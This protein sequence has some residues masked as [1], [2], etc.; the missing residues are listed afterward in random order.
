MLCLCHIIFRNIASLLLNLIKKLNMSTRI[1]TYLT[2]NG[3]CRQAMSFYK[4]C[5]GGELQLQ[6][7]GDSPLAEKMPKQMRD[8]ILHSTLTRD[9]LILMGSDMVG[10]KGLTKGNAVSLMLNCSSETE[11]KKIYENLSKGGEATHPLEISFWGAL[12]GDLTD[13]F[14]N[15]WLLHFDKT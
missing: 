12:F 9:G 10:D 1:N 2:F 14:G 4:D 5:L 6:T 3:N 13:K 8:C 15:Q 11:I 7:I